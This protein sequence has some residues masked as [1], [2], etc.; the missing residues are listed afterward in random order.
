MVEGL[1]RVNLVGSEWTSGGLIW[2]VEEFFWVLSGGFT[3]GGINLVGNRGYSGWHR[4]RQ[5]QSSRLGGSTNLNL[6]EVPEV[7]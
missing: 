3:D 1:R 4:A 6:L 7:I 5:P 2:M